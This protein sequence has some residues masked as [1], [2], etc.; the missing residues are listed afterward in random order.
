MANL[1]SKELTGLDDQLGH[2]QILVKKYMAM[3]CGCSD[4]A[5]KTK[6]EQIKRTLFYLCR[7][8]DHRGSPALSSGQQL[9]T[10]QSFYEGHSL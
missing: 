2:E 6:F 4:L 7:S 8:Y 5:L 1:T 9:N 10:S 3:A